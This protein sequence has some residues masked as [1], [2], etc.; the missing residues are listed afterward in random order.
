MAESDTRK[1]KRSH[2]RKPGLKLPSLD[3]YQSIYLALASLVIT[4]LIAG[5]WL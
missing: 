3:S 4:A 5:A 1:P 2:R